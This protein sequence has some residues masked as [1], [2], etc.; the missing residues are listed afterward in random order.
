MAKFWR[1]PHN[2]E[3]THSTGDSAN[4]S[5]RKNIDDLAMQKDGLV[6]DDDWANIH[7]QLDSWKMK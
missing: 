5:I 3:G 1:S 6:K 4:I 2:L 7:G